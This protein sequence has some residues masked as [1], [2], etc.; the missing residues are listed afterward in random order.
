MATATL[1]QS[2][3]VGLNAAADAECY[4]LDPPLPDPDVPGVEHEYVVVV[5]HPGIKQ[6]SLPSLHLYASNEKGRVVGGSMRALVTYAHPWEPTAR[7]GLF[8]AGYE[9]IA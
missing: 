9:V 3:I 5:T 7:G 8:L 6:H 4:R 2:G 1:V